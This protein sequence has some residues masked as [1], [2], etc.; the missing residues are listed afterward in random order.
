MPRLDFVVSCPVG[1]SFAVA[2]VAGMFDVPLAERLTERFA[3]DVPDWLVPAAGE[4]A[5]RIGLV[6][7]P[8]ASGKTTI[9]RRLFGAA[10]VE[11]A[12]W[13]ADRA[14]IDA[15][16]HLPT[17]RATGLL[18]SVGLG[19]AP[20]WI[21]PYHVLSG[22]ERFR[23]DLARA[24]AEHCDD[25]H[26]IVVCDEFTSVVDRRAAQLA[27][28]ALARALR[29]EQIRCRLVAVTSHDDVAPWLAPDWVLDTRTR[30]FSRGLLQ[31]PPMQL[32]LYGCARRAWRLFAPHHYLSG[33]LSAAARAFVAL[34]AGQPPAVS[35]VEPAA[36]C[37]T[38]SQIGRRGRRR[39]SRLV[40]LPDYQ[41]L[42]IGAAVAEAVGDWHLQRG[43]RLSVTASHRALV[44]HCRRSPRW[45]F[46]AQ[47]S[48]G[49]PRAAPAANYRDAAG[50]AVASF[51]Y[52]GPQ[53]PKE[54]S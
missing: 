43:E 8:S 42:G 27:S 6:V 5:W 36:F 29:R 31:R 48:A 47:R 30:Q 39:I 18:T 15:F 22:G 7:G 19:S 51:E 33:Q 1:P 46:V 26:A 3:L 23:C 28:A 14:V 54:T 53:P 41:G 21:K 12:P 37:A 44:A 45:R 13:P 32:E 49:K 20:A 17:Q 25:P 34:C 2:Q 52:L 11:P 4:P 16:A 24:L 38:V 50:R 40:V 10:L 35:E 9:A